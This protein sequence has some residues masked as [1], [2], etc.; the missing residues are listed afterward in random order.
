MEY[1]WL[2]GIGSCKDTD[3]SARRESQLQIPIVLSNCNGL[4]AS[5][6]ETGGLIGGRDLLGT[7]NSCSVESQYW[8][9]SA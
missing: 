5:L 7:V 1:H 8:L 6:S 9:I 2:A 4:C 3:G